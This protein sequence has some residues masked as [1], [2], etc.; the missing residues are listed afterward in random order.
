MKLM[1]TIGILVGGT[2]FG[3]FGQLMDHGNWLGGWSILLGTI[4]SIIGVWAGY[5]AYKNFF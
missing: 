2:V 3:W 4:G 1:I 5:K